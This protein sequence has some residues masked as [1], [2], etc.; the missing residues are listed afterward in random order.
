MQ[1]CCEIV[2]FNKILI[3]MVGMIANGEI[4]SGQT[5]GVEYRVV[6]GIS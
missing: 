2:Y 4:D 3:D 5:G 6:V 1:D